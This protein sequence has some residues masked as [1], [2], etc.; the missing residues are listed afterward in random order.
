ME[1]DME[2]AKKHRKRRAPWFSSTSDVAG[3][4]KALLQA[5]PQGS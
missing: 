2:D 4:S 3:C 1:S 5:L